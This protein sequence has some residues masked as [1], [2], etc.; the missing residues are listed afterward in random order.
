[1]TCICSQFP[2]LELDRRSIKKRMK[3]TAAILK[4][5]QLLAENEALR[6]KLL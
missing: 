2:P 1:M 5:L 4:P 3:A 6:L